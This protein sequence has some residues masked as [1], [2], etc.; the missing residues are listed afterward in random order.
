MILL[1]LEST[2]HEAHEIEAPFQAEEGF[3]AVVGLIDATHVCI[4]A[5]EHEPDSYINC[6]KFHSLNLQVS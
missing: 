6:K 4:R 1:K 2:A 5:P 3:P